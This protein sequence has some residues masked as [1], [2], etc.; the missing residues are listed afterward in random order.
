MRYGQYLTVPL[1]TVDQQQNEI[2][3]KAASLLVGLIDRDVDSDTRPI[4]LEPRLV[5]RT[6]SKKKHT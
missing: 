1:S 6:S 4:L 2:G 5:I 3:K